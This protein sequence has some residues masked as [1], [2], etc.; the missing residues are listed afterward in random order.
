VREPPRVDDLEVPLEHGRI[1]A[2]RS[3][4]LYLLA[5]LE[6]EPDRRLAARAL[7]ADHCLYVRP[8]NPPP[9]QAA[10]DH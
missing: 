10:D 9:T 7:V 8:R 4:Q 6:K 2:S 5:V 1:S 3:R